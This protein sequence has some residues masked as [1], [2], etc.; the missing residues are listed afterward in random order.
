MF[1]VVTTMAFAL[2]G[3]K[4]KNILTN[5]LQHQEE[6]R[7]IYL[8]TQAERKTEIE[9]KPLCYHDLMTLF[10]YSRKKIYFPINKNY[11]MSTIFLFT[12]EA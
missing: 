7:R 10:V 1:F 2:F 12:G 4:N 5:A 11:L 6:F 8:T 3:Q 9:Q